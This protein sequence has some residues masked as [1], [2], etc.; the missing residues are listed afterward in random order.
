M[1]R[2]RLTRAAWP[3]A[4]ALL[5]ACAS[6]GRGEPLPMDVE[7]AV[8]TMAARFSDVALPGWA[9][10]APEP[11]AGP[12][13]V[14]VLGFTTNDG[15]TYLGERIAYELSVA[16]AEALRE[17]PDPHLQVITRYHLDDLLREQ[18]L[19]LLDP[20]ALG[21]VPHVGRLLHADYLVLGMLSPGRDVVHVSAQMLSVVDGVV[22]AGWR[23][24]LRADDDV[25]AQL[26][27][28]PERPVL[29]WSSRRPPA[30]G[31]G[32]WGTS[33]ST[34]APASPS[35]APLG[36]PAVS[37]DV[38]YDDGP[39]RPRAAA[40]EPPPV[41]AAGRP[42]LSVRASNDSVLVAPDGRPVT[43]LVLLVQ[44]RDA[45]GVHELRFE[46]AP[47]V[48]VGADGD[49]TRR[50]GGGVDA[51]LGVLRPGTDV[52]RV[53]EVRPTGTLDAGALVELGRV[54]LVRREGGARIVQTVP[55]LAT[56]TDDP[57]RH[58][59]G[60]RPSVSAAAQEL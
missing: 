29:A 41:A 9:E 25:V 4:A 50:Q 37:R 7:T 15:A 31:G 5:A 14:G 8:S 16:L 54:E 33:A 53:L 17:H 24:R 59:W 46:P 48:E 18:G 1:H 58:R 10:G 34:R 39:A 20:F 30:L 51:D 56:T 26:R 32:S 36:A 23:A 44:V 52:R 2:R 22:V 45:V 42:G 49:W 3:A 40:D 27:R 43:S 6:T 38:T 21:D 57:A 19:S 28:V 13:A 12:P 11:E 35:S 55:V 47:G 60:D